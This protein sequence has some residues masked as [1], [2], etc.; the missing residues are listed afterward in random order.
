MK[1]IKVRVWDGNTMHYPD[2][3]YAYELTYTRAGAWQLWWNR[4]KL[5]AGQFDDG[6]FFLLYT[7]LKDLNGVEIYGGDI[8]KHEIYHPPAE[9]VGTEF[10]VVEFI[11][12]CFMA[13]LLG[14]L[15]KINLKDYFFE[16][17]GNIHEN[18]ELKNNGSK[19]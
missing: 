3:N 12:G 18:P 17:V 11:D 15:L 16:V 2:N 8:L 6:V 7:G 13:V 10:Y 19:T 9:H 14:G 1:E 5:I 4:E